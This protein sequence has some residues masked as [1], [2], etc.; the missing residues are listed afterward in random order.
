MD[1]R[2]KAITQDL[3]GSGGNGNGLVLT[4][5]SFVRSLFLP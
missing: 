1:Q 3:N 2:V 4:I 5:E